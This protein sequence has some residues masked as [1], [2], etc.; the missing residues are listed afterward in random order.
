MRSPFGVSGTSWQNEE[1]YSR[2]S[3]FTPATPLWC[4][5]GKSHRVAWSIAELERQYGE[6]LFHV[7]DDVATGEPQLVQLS[8]FIRDATNPAA[9]HPYIFDSTFDMSAPGLTQQYCT[10]E[11]LGDDSDL[12]FAILDPNERPDHKWLLVGPMGSG[13]KFHA[14]PLGSAWN[15]VMEGAKRWVVVE[16]GL[17]PPTAT[18]PGSSLHSWFDHEWGLWRDQLTR[19]GRQWY[20]FVQQEG[21]VVYIPQGWG[22]AVINLSSFT[23]AVTHNLVTAADFEGCW[24]VVRERHPQLAGHWSKALSQNSL[25]TASPA[26]GPPQCRR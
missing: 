25:Y 7:G 3:L 11:H 14:D 23:V 10:P 13:S 2:P 26:I 5:G 22:H 17:L 9:E 1:W 6:E 12:L 19:E 24:Q 8:D 4:Y 18:P 15:G 16:P 20:D 21:Q